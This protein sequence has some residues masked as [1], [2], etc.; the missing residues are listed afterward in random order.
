MRAI[1]I[2]I[3]LLAVG[4]ESKSKSEPLAPDM[5]EHPP[6]PTISAAPGSKPSKAAVPEQ[7]AA[8]PDEAPDEAPGE[9]AEDEDIAR[10]PSAMKRARGG[11]GAVGTSGSGSGAAS[12]GGS[13]AADSLDGLLEADAPAAWRVQ[14]VSTDSTDEA[15]VKALLRRREGALRRC[16]SFL[17]K[18]VTR[19]RCNVSFDGALPKSVTTV[20]AHDTAAECVRSQ[21]SKTRFPGPPSKLSFDLRR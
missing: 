10:E 12:S 15:K 7:Q 6:I 14:L 17:A 1:A 21:L 4:C 11:V 19:L 20:P 3:I 8:P 9:D 2:I 16:A 5:G 18:D 13:G